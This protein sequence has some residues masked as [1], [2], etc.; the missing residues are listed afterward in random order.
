M[1][2]GDVEVGCSRA[3]D[4][5]DRLFL[6]APMSHWEGWR[7]M[8]SEFLAALALDAGAA[9]A[10]CFGQGPLRLFCRAFVLSFCLKG[11]GTRS[12][13]FDGGGIAS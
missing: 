1:A 2:V 13:A 4:C 10:A 6:L 9:L 3:N 5:R 12:R 7:A 11:F 8:V